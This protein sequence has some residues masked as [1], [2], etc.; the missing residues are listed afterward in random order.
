[1]F[2]AAYNS[3]YH[4]PGVMWA[5]GIPIL[6]LLAWRER[7]SFLGWALLA[8]QAAILL[9]AWLT[10][11]LSPLPP[12]SAGAT[13]AGVVFVI[14][15]DLRYF[16]LLERFGHEA[17]DRPLRWLALPLGYSLLVPVLAHVS[18]RVFPSSELRVVF[19]TYEL[20]FAA[21]ALSIRFALLPRRRGEAVGFVTWLTE[22]QIAQYGLWATADVIILA[23]YDVGYALRF[24]PNLMY[25]VGFVPFAWRAAAARAP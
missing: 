16:V 6:A 19:L 23:G 4:H 17:G 22:Y 11:H 15:G 12:G 9:D 2:E 8:F 25:Y 1:M 14:L 21:L 3:V 18:S 24:V 7:K 10:G 13:A 5:A 20:M